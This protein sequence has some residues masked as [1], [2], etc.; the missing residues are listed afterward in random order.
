MTESDDPLAP[1]IARLKEPAPLAPDLADRVMAEIET[2]SARE[3]GPIPVP[4]WRRRRTI[5]VSPLG[6]LALA[7]GLAA[8]ALASQLLSRP[9][10]RPAP[11]APGS[12]GAQP[13]QFILVAPE[14]AAVTVVGDFNDWSVSA[15]PLVRAQ[16]DGVW[17]VTVPLAPGR[18]RYAFVVDGTV[19]RP[20]PEA[21]AGDDE[22]GRPSSVL[23]IGG[24]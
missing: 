22:F 5:Q 24:A 11:V 16:G 10:A 2:L 6:G 13:T 14:A 9:A 4:W 19:W 7:A 3:P 15:T 18:Y 23:T 17:W 20:D 8:I 12:D 21:P 1:L